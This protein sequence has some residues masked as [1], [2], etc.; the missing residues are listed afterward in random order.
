M[1]NNRPFTVFY[2]DIERA[3]EIEGYEYH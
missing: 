3:I 2:I 1:N